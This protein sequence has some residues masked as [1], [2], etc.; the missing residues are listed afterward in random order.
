MFGRRAMRGAR[1][2]MAQDRRR[3]RL[4]NIGRKRNTSTVTPIQDRGPRRAVDPIKT[5]KRT[6]RSVKPVQGSGPKM[7]VD[8]LRPSKPADNTGVRH[9]GQGKGG[10]GGIPAVPRRGPQPIVDP[11]R[12]SKPAG[13]RHSGQGRG[14]RGGIPDVNPFG[15]RRIIPKPKVP[16]LIATPYFKGGKVAPTKNAVGTNDY[17]KT[18][19]TL[20]VKDNRKKTK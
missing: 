2:R 6:T 3:R 18:G 12:P 5:P 20:S 15:Q 14:G 4:A 19:T 13:A 16:K 9:S 1:R 17:R 7:I 10:R 8:P 11:L